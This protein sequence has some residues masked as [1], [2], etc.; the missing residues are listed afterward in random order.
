MKIHSALALALSLAALA[1]CSPKAEKDPAS[2]VIERFA[3]KDLPV[4]ISLTLEKQDG[5]D[6]FTTEVSD[7][8]LKIEASSPVAAT[9][10]F[11]EYVKENGDGINSWTGNRLEWP[12]ELPDMEKEE[13]VSP[14][15]HHYYFNVVTFGYSMPYWDWARWEKEIDWMALHGIDMPLALVGN[16]AITAR[17]WKKLGLTDEEISAY[18]T[19]PAHL[20]WMRMGNISSVDGPMPEEWHQGQIELQHKILDRMKSLGMKPIT[21]AFAGFVPEGIKRLY[22]DVELLETSWLGGVSKNWMVS[23]DSPLFR[24]I[25]QMFIEEWEKEFGKNDYYIADS[26]NEMDIPFPP[27]GTQER[28]D[29]LAKYGDEVYSSIKAGNPDAVWVMQGWMFGYMRQIWDY[30][31]LGALLSKVPDDKMLLLDLAVDYNNC[32]WKLDYN[33]EFYKGFFNKD[34]VYSVIPNMGGKNALSGIPEFYANNRFEALNSPN[35]GKLAGYGMAPEG[36]ENNEVIYELITDAGWTDKKIDLPEWYTNYTIN[37]YGQTDE[38]LSEAWEKLQNSVYG[39]LVDNPRYNWQFRPGTMYMGNVNVNDDFY[40][41]IEDFAKPAE[42]LASSPLYVDDLIENT[43]HYL[44]AKMEVLLQNW[45]TEFSNN[46]MDSLVKIE[47][48]FEEL[49]LAADRLL[50]SHPTMRLEN[51]IEKA[52]AVGDTEELKDY[53]EHNARRIV[54]VWFKPPLD[55]YAARIWSGLIRDYYLPRWQQ[56]FTAMRNDE[57]MD[58]ATWENEWVDSEGL[59]EMQ[60]YANP[61]EACQELIATAKAIKPIDTGADGIQRI[62]GWASADFRDGDYVKQLWNLPV[63]KAKRLKEVRLL[64]TRGDGK[65]TLDNLNLEMDGINYGPTSTKILPDGTICCYFNVPASA[66]GNNA[67]RLTAKIS[68]EPGKSSFGKV[69]IVLDPEK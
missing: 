55:D 43:V 5:R 21:P 61:V 48:Q 62:G 32:F 41:A 22:P 69:S 36:I 65:I 25:G 10:A 46:N 18:F 27:K 64:Q 50:C 20:P 53:Y 67:C 14:F 3:G 26:F 1:G 35:R 37:R 13:T 47:K 42:K 44:G 30:E 8:R 51:W 29:L 40:E 66:T 6:V 56:Y 15:K 45:E 63:A 16:E 9:R 24:Q 58:I 38:D 4:D 54:T 28:T 12:S 52:R 49:A 11:Y 59:S 33:W 17:V 68:R 31:T 39:T 34:W 7:G 19:G 57:A 2:A 23:P 60:P